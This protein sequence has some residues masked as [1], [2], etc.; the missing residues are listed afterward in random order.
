M[1]Y[2]LGGLM[3]FCI[4]FTLATTLGLSALALDLPI[5]I[6]ESN[7]GAAVLVA[8]STENLDPLATCRSRISSCWALSLCNCS[9]G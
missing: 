5:S 9:Q 8:K 7:A 1:G 3:W 6:A 2:L 4:P